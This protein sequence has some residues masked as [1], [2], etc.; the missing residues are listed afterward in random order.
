VICND[1]VK[2]KKRC[3]VQVVSHSKDGVQWWRWPGV[4]KGWD[5]RRIV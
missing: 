5:R 4:G 1:D 3:G 2:V